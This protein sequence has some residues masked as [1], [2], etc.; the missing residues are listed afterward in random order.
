MVGKRREPALG[1][2]RISRGRGLV[3]EQAGERRGTEALGTARE[4]L[5][6]GG[7]GGGILRG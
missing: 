3:S 7:K 4:E 5:T 2:R 1:S 6:A